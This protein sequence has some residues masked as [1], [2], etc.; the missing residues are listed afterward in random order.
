MTVEV[1]KTE[2]AEVERGLDYQVNASPFVPATIVEEE[3]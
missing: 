2:E 1:L 3:N